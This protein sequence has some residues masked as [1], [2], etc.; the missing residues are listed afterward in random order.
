MW[1]RRVW[2]LRLREGVGGVVVS[3]RSMLVDVEPKCRRECD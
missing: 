3:R 2:R 1:S